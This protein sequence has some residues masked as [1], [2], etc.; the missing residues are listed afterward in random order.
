MVPATDKGHLAPRKNWRYIL[1]STD[2]LIQFTSLILNAH[3]EVVT[4]VLTSLHFTS[5]RFD[6]RPFF[7]A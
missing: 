7:A 1:S 4:A 5:L 2:L 3:L 6:R